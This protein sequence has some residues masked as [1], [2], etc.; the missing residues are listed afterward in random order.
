[1]VVF[2]FAGND[3]NLKQYLAS[4]LSVFRSTTAVLE[5]K[6]RRLENDLD[7]KIRETEA[8]RRELGQS[9]VEQEQVGNKMKLT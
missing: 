7:E 5:T 9:R 2:S 8:L 6:T 1:M 4:R 3:E